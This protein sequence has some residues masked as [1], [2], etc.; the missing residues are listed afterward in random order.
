MALMKSSKIPKD[1]VILDEMEAAGYIW[2]MIADWEPLSDIWALRYGAVALGAVSSLSG[3][4]INK[5]YRWRFK[6]GN[7]G[8][9]SSTI[10]IVVMP[11]LL[12]LLFHKQLVTTNMLLMKNNACP[13]CHEIKSG[14]LQ[15]GFGIGYPMLLAPTS[16]LMFANRYATYRVPHLTE[17]VKVMFKFLRVHTKSL[18][19]TLAYI[20]A[21]QLAA[22]AVVTYFEMRNNI[23]LRNKLAEI[24]RKLE[25]GL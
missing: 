20:A 25:S 23:T 18:T 6:L 22:S 3:L 12:T 9:L 10:P 17:G 15:L 21:L 14:V 4:L 5:H 13:I 24:E 7:Y 2:N 1:A 11:G 8:Y 19:G 16:A